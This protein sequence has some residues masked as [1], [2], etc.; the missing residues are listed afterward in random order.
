MI[1]ALE[2]NSEGTLAEFLGNFPTVSYVFV[3]SG[4][5]LV[6]FSVEPIIALVVEHA[7]I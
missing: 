2:N 4:D 6:A 7:H 3:D 1:I 5:I